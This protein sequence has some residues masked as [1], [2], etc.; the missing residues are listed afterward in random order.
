MERWRKGTF[1]IDLIATLDVFVGM[2][3]RC[4]H[5]VKKMLGQQL[6]IDKLR[7]H[8]ASRHLLARGPPLSVHSGSMLTNHYR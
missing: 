7:V 1:R 5:C 6:F 4:V 2:D 3:N 8:N